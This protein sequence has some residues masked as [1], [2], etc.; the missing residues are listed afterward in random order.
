[1]TPTILLPWQHSWFQSLS[2]KNQISPFATL[3]SGTWGL[4]RNRHG[5]HIVLT[6]GALGQG[7]EPQ[8]PPMEQGPRIQE[9]N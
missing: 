1:M 4:P 7:V 6:G 8:I 5:S 2:V 9:V 3:F